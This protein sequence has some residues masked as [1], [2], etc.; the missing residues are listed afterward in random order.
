MTKD[1][2]AEFHL[3][4]LPASKIF[5]KC[6]DDTMILVYDK[7]YPLS[8]VYADDLE[9]ALDGGSSDEVV[10]ILHGMVDEIEAAEEQI[11]RWRRAHPVKRGG[12]IIGRWLHD[13][14][15]ALQIWGC[16]DQ[17]WADADHGVPD[18]E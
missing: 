18:R 5:D 17:E 11:Q 2:L 16:D 12:H 8:G 1:Q 13:L 10:L 4:W 14:G 9:A 6:S 7:C 3:S 15:R